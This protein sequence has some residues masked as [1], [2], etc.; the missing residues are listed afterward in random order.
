MVFARPLPLS[1]RAGMARG[2]GSGGHRMN[3][4]LGF[5]RVGLPPSWSTRRIGREKPFGPI[6]KPS[7]ISANSPPTTERS[8]LLISE[9]QRMKAFMKSG[10]VVISLRSATEVFSA[11]WRKLSAFIATPAVAAVPPTPPADLQ[12]RF[13]ELLSFASTFRVPP[14]APATTSR[15][16][17][18]PA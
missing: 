1:M 14:A 6:L 5:R 15:A 10:P 3:G 9:N 12:P 2:E 17:P 13:V 11:F 18:F 8:S 16:G 4:R 7:K